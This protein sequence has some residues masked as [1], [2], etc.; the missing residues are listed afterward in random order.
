MFVVLCVINHSHRGQTIRHSYRWKSCMLPCRSV[1]RC[2]GHPHIAGFLHGCYGQRNNGLRVSLPSLVPPPPVRVIHVRDSPAVA[3]A[4]AFHMWGLLVGQQ[5]GSR[6]QTI[7]RSGLLP[8][9]RSQSLCV[10]ER[11]CVCVCVCMCVPLSRWCWCVPNCK[12]HVAS[13]RN[14]C[15]RARGMCK[16]FATPQ[17][18]RLEAN[19]CKGGPMSQRMLCG[20]S[21]RYCLDSLL[22]NCPGMWAG[23]VSVMKERER[24]KERGRE[25]VRGGRRR[26]RG[27]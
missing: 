16:L 19:Y 17:S 15:E 5:L 14:S 6:Y 18:N 7:V 27:T 21:L 25:G 9:A 26:E 1:Q 3:V 2:A 24:E 23:P 11:V 10:C 4:T 12:F 13:G 8:H 20:P 22:G